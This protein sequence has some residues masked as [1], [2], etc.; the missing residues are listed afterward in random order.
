M[1]EG[2]VGDVVH[3]LK[4]AREEGGGALGRRGIRRIGEAIAEAG[5]EGGDAA[6]VVVEDGRDAGGVLVVVE[7]EVDVLW[8]KAVPSSPQTP[9]KITVLASSALTVKFLL[10]GGD[11]SRVFVPSQLSI[12]PGKEIVFKNNVGFPHNVVFDEDKIP[13]GVDAGAIS[14][15]E[16]D[17]LNGLG[18]TYKVTLKEKG[19]NSFYCS[20]HQGAGILEK[21]TVN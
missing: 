18:E 7:A 2:D 13:L 11:R 17:L 19:S 21:I 1:C 10:G 14:M 6:G 8:E 20:P 5:G 9:E 16:E 4:G 15:S 3:A 12:A